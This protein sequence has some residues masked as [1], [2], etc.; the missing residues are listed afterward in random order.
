MLL[1]NILLRAQDGFEK[2]IEEWA[3][4][5]KIHTA[6]FD[7]KESLFEVTDALVIIHED[8]NISREHNDLRSGIEKQ[9]KST[10][11]IDING[12]KSASVN[13]FRFWL[14]NNKP[15]NL[16]VV[17]NDQLIENPRLKTY[18]EKLSEFI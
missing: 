2:S 7:G 1:K 14:E 12:T 16:L 6:Y 17:G 10:H 4:S 5:N 18:F 11:L 9:Y 13:S 8:H 3:K 15:T